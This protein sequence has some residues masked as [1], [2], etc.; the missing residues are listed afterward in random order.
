MLAPDEFVTVEKR[1]FLPQN[2]ELE[3]GDPRAPE[4]LAFP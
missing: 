1:R 2:P 4:A 3:L